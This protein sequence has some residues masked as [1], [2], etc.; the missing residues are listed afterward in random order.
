[1]CCFLRFL[2]FSAK[3]CLT[4]VL[5]QDCNAVVNCKNTAGPLMLLNL[6]FCHTHWARHVY[7][8]Y[9]CFVKHLQNW[10]NK[11]LF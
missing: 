7:Y 11:I 9:M 3:I 10:Q 2:A 4:L 6:V 5:Y 1:M 8:Q